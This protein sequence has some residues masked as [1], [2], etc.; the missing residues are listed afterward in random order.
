MIIESINRGEA[1]RYMGI[2]GAPDLSV[3][4][5][6]DVCERELLSE[7]TPKF[8]WTFAEISEHSETETKLAGYKLSLCGKD[9]SAWLD[10]CYG[11]VMLCAT[12]GEGADRLLR[13][14][15]SEDMAKALVCDAL[16]SAAIEQVCDATVSEIAE[17]FSESF[18]TDRFS[19]GY[20]DFPIEVQEE[21]L[22]AANAQKVIGLCVTPSGILTPTKSVTAVIGLHK[23]S[24]DTIKRNCESCNLKN[25]CTFRRTGGNCNA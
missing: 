9:I 16:A 23:N 6:A 3:T 22:L 13:K 11:A 21:F 19:P 12:L 14:C 8:C 20:G 10:G 18:L 25:R 5:L 4:A 1:Y 7:I 17:R 24:T 15:R 2:K